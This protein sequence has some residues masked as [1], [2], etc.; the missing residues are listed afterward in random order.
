MILITKCICG[1]LQGLINQVTPNWFQVDIF[2]LS[3]ENMSDNFI[4]LTVKLK[5]KNFA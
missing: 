4:F 1:H 5:F 2:N 3:H